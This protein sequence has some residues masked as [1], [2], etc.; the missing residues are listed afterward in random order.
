MV[1]TKR[2]I[3]DVATG[4]IREEEIEFEEVPAPAYEPAGIDLMKLKEEIDALKKDIN[5]LKAINNKVKE[6]EKKGW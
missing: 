3:Y 6:I 1:K 2:F 5:E 4:E